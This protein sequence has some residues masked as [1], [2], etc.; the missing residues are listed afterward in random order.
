MRLDREGRRTV[1]QFLNGLSVG[2]LATL[3]LAPLASGTLKPALAVAAGLG[4]AVCH[5]LA[6][7][8]GRRSG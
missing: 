4:A 6:L 8:L 2:M 1:A 3:V 7:H 5:W